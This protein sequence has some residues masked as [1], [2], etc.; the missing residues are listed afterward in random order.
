MWN[1]PWGEELQ[2]DEIALTL[3]GSP[4]GTDVPYANHHLLHGRAGLEPD[5]VHRL[6][7]QRPRRLDQR[8]TGAEVD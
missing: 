8:P 6:G 2:A 3:A 7:R 1:V 4:C 5:G